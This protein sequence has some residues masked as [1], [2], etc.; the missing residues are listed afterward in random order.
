MHPGDALTFSYAGHEL[1]G[2]LIK[3]DAGLLTVKLKSGY[4]IIL[5]KTH[6]EGLKVTTASAMPKQAKPAITQKPG[7]PKITILHTG[8]TIASKVDYATGAVIAGYSAEEILGLYPELLE[9]ADVSS[10]LLS[11]I[12]SEMLRFGHWNLMAHAVKEAVASGAEGVIITHGTDVLAVTSAALA[13]ALPGLP[14][15]LL[16]VGSQRSSDRPSSDAP[17][18]LLAAVQFILQERANFKGVGICLHEST[19]NDDCV[20]LPGLRA[21]KLH[22]SRRDAFRPVNDV[23]FARIAAGTHA[24]ERLHEYPALPNGPFAV[25][26]FD[27]N[28]RIGLLAAHPHMSAREFSTFEG[29]DGL[30]IELL[31]IGHLPT[32]QTDE[33]NAENAAIFEEIKKLCSAM[34]V[35]G[36]PRTVY[37]R[38]NMNV[39][40]PG[41]Q[42]L[43][44]GMLGQGLDMTAETAFV[45]LA[46]LLS[47]HRDDARR[48]FGENLRGEISEQS[49]Q[50]GFIEEKKEE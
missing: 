38:I 28:L 24:I 4:N 6:A 10:R 32:M 47:N 49:T 12:Q 13:F 29:F 15:P 27:P 16:L 43:A 23:P 31:G 14:V 44:A 25:K 37:G 18:N 42:L 39:Y 46:W 45:K 34:P 20:I 41:R 26:P 11:N 8:G 5:E 21:R 9:V 35:V 36:A 3:E 48:L 1:N 22:T 30:V 40:S 17:S 50:E 7:L 19:R 33:H 2:T